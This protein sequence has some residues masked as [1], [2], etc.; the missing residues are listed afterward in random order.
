[1]PKCY[2]QQE[3]AY[4]IQKLKE[5][6]KKCIAQYGI[7]K[8]TV[9]EIVKRAKIPK[10]TFYLFYPTKELLLFEC[11]LEVHEELEAKILDSFSTINLQNVSVDELSDLLFRLFQLVNEIPILKILAHEDMEILARKL[12]PEVIANHLSEDHTMLNQMFASLSKNKT[13]YS[14]A[15]STA[16]RNIFLL[17]IERED[18]NDPHFDASIKL[19]LR[20][21][22]MQLLN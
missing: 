3:R 21:L 15:F 10:G 13:I 18:F 5:E 17:V 6:S 19:L 8:T 4:I 16:F 9:D 1:M 2:S 14:E 20:G 11:I 22:V 12:P 7:K